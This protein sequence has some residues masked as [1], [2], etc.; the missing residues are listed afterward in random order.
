MWSNLTQ[1]LQTSASRGHDSRILVKSSCTRCSPKQSRSRVIKL[2]VH[3][4]V[5]WARGEARRGT[6][7]VLRRFSSHSRV[8]GSL[9]IPNYIDKSKVMVMSDIYF[10]IF[11]KTLKY[12]LHS[13]P[14]L[15]S[16]LFIWDNKTIVDT[17][18]A[19]KPSINAGFVKVCLRN[20]MLHP[21][22]SK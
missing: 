2:M 9:V 4:Q 13:I 22:S 11:I 5:T 20:L 7:Q 16:C 21:K 3:T 14:S 19:Q 15:Y 1:K 17:A 8:Y 10:N 6:S 18:T 12:K